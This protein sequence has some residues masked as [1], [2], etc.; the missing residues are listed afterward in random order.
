MIE[1]SIE[2][3]LRQKETNRFFMEFLKLKR[4]DRLYRI[5]PQME[6]CLSSFLKLHK[7]LRKKGLNPKNVE[8]FGDAI[9]MGVVKLPE[10]QDQHRKLQD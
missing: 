2:L 3:G 4:Q 10:L 7:T 8:W 6:H 5:Y 9:E 1:V